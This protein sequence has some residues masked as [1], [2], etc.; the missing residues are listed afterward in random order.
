MSHALLATWLAALL[1]GCTP[2]AD[3]PTSDLHVVEIVILDSPADREQARRQELNDL[4]R[5]ATPF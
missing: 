3:V 5:V 1:A 4:F 2:L